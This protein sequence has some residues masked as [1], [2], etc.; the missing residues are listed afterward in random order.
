MAH[1]NQEFE[2]DDPFKEEE[3]KV[4]DEVGCLHSEHPAPPARNLHPAPR[5]PAP[6]SQPRTWN[7]S[8]MRAAAEPTRSSGCWQQ[9]GAS[10]AR[11][12][13]E[14]PPTPRVPDPWVERQRSSLKP[15][16]SSLLPPA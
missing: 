9:R 12:R 4:D 11:P 16:P 8:R 15:T 13:Q 3:K 5:I 7:R 1:G 2:G 10:Q 6:P 14:A